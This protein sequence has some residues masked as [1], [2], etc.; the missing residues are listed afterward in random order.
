MWDWAEVQVGGSA[1]RYSLNSSGTIFTDVNGPI[2]YQETGF[3]TQA[4]KKMMDD[5]MVLTAAI[6]YD[7]SEL[8]DGQSHQERY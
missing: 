5:R 4:V 8:F 6:R 3:Y 2:E 7:K 1:R